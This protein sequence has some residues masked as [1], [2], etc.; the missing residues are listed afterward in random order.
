M[1]NK[2]EAEAGSVWVKRDGK[3]VQLVAPGVE[4]KTRPVVER[5]S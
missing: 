4:P 3:W 2:M 1:T 5:T